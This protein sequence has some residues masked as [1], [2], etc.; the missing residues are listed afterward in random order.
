MAQ[1]NGKPLSTQGWYFATGYK[2][3][4][5]TFADSAPSWL[6]PWEFTFRYETMGNIMVADLNNPA[7]TD[8]FKTTVYTAGINYYIKGHNAKIQGNYNWVLEPEDD[9]SG[10]GFREVRNDNFIVNFQV[11]F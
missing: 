8:V 5:S 2:L 6:K 4:D 7:H 11:A 9:H 1:S 10:R 3:S